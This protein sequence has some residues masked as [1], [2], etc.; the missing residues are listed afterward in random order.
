[1]VYALHEARKKASIIVMGIIFPVVFIYFGISLDTFIAGCL[2]SF[3]VN[4]AVSVFI[5]LHLKN[6]YVGKDVSAVDL[7]NS[8]KDNTE[9]ILDE[10]AVYEGDA[11]EKP[12]MVETP[13][14]S[15]VHPLT[16]RIHEISEKVIGKF[17]DADIFDWID[18]EASDGKIYRSV[19]AGTVDFSN[20]NQIIPKHS[21]AVSTGILYQ[22]EG[23]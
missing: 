22:V 12:M 21:F 7:V 14:E 6:K 20:P 13:Q 9:E 5:A 4:W 19:F 3:V 10:M 1:M 15:N 23:L 17:K 11:G 2:I 8:I 18:V 16:F